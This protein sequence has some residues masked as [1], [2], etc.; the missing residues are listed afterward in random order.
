LRGF[1]GSDRFRTPTTR[2]AAKK[3]A[4]ATDMKK[5]NIPLRPVGGREVRR[6]IREAYGAQETMLERFARG[7]HAG[8]RGNIEFIDTLQ[9]DTL[10]SIAGE[11]F[12]P[13]AS[14]WSEIPPRA[15]PQKG[16][17]TP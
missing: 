10:A 7:G 17:H 5:G 14:G 2:T 4:I 16:S 15:S 11:L 1:L 8:T 6:L 3:A 13:P 12:S 9:K